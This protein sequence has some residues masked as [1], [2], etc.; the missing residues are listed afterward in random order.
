M[1]LH[2]ISLVAE[3]SADGKMWDFT[4]LFFECNRK[5]VVCFVDVGKAKISEMFV[6]PESVPVG[7][8]NIGILEFEEEC[9]RHL[10]ISLMESLKKRKKNM[11]ALLVCI[12][13]EQDKERR[14][15]LK[16][17]AEK[18]EKKIQ[19]YFTRIGNRLLVSNRRKYETE[20]GELLWEPIGMNPL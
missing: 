15:I 8:L 9:R 13:N 5:E 11:S 1:H 6:T 2:K 14:T 10:R 16:S 20:G 3:K 17:L 12:Q 7:H 18:Q 19:G 4:V